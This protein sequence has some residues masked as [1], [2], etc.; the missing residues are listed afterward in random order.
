[1]QGGL[2]SSSSSCFVAVM[3]GRVASSQDL[4]GAMAAKRKV[5]M[6]TRRSAE[7]RSMAARADDWLGGYIGVWDNESDYKEWAGFREPQPRD[8]IPLLEIQ[9]ILQQDT[10]NMVSWISHRFKKHKDFHFEFATTKRAR[11]WCRAL[12]LLLTKLR[13]LRGL[14]RDEK[15]AG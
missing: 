11:Q 15:K 12:E 9:D 13:V 2:V 1:M 8:V 14:R 4:L 5:A 10:V 6:K 3:D 7:E